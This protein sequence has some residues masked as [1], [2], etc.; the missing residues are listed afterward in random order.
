MKIKPFAPPTPNKPAS[1][2]RL[3]DRQF[4]TRM[5]GVRK[6][7]YVR[8]I[9]PEDMTDEDVEDVLKLFR[10]WCEDWTPK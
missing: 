4:E 5:R 6:S 3:T 8:G 1:S 9:R 7:M 10:M 2:G